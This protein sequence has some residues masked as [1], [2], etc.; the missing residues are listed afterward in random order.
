VDAGLLVLTWKGFLLHEIGF[1]F[2]VNRGHEDHNGWIKGFTVM[3]IDGI[4]PK[5]MMWTSKEDMIG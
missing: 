4:G 3:E 2:R 1:V 5:G